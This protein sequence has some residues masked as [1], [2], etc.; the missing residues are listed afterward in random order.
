M[1]RSRLGLALFLF[2]WG[3]AGAVPVVR[4][5]EPLRLVLPTRN[6]ALYRGDGPAFYMFTDRIENGRKTHPWEGGR[7]GFV[8]NAKETAGG[9]VFTRFHEGLDIRPVY[10]D[11]DG[12]PLDS[13]RAIDDGSV[14]YV[15]TVP[16][17]SSYG[18]YVVV[19][20][21]WSGTPFYSLYAH[22]KGVNVRAGQEVRQGQRLGM[23][24]YTGRGIDRRRAHVHFE[25]NML[26]HQD[27]ARWHGAA[28]RSSNQHGAF[29][30][31]NLAGLD[32]AALYLALH[33]DPALTIE[34]FFAEQEPFFKVAV[35]NDGA[36]D[37]L[38]RYPFLA[39]HQPWQ[40]REDVA[41]RT[42]AWEISFTQT[43]VPIRFE[44]L[45]RPVSAP[46]ATMVQ[47]SSIPYTYLTGGTLTGSGRSYALASEGE[48]YMSLLLYPPSG[49]A[50][51]P[52]R[53][54][55]RES[56]A[57][58]VRSVDHTAGPHMTTPRQTTPQ[59]VE[60]LTT[61]QRSE[62]GRTAPPRTEARKAE[63]RQAEPSPPAET[64][65]VDEAA[66]RVATEVRT[67]Q[68]AKGGKE[69]PRRRVRG[70]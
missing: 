15:N 40:S 12:E 62:A 3:M 23:L 68:E 16:T 14:V 48:R 30:G 67:R 59:P 64:L 31:L 26:L 51:R 55:Y 2:G 49:Q 53:V 8:R 4:A 35:P 50:Y 22:L 17:A 9:T 1:L 69:T 11:A 52:R 34:R 36:I 28:A 56:A 29:N 60:A 61:P 25:I 42:V 20:H 44:P 41:R 7:Y 57:A 27:Y 32:V 54:T 33:R 5:G 24:G 6:D 10:R 13:V 39:E 38:Q 19:E 66:R 58:P 18:K 46:L 21:W 47:R 37:L 70:W 45:A 65:T 63:P 43:G